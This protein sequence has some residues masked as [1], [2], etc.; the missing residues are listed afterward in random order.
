MNR[1]ILIVGAGQLGS[2]HL[3]ALALCL[4]PCEIFVVDPL[5]ESLKVAKSRFE[6]ING[7][8]K[9]NV[10]YQSYIDELESDHFEIA[11]ISTNA[12][13]RSK[14]IK[15]LL[16][17]KSISIFILEK[18][19]FQ[20][21]MEYD[22]IEMLF[23]RTKSKAF[24]NC[25]RRMF[26]FYK[27]VK[28]SI[29]YETPIHIEVIGNAWGLG[30]NSIHFIDLF[31]FL[32]GEN[33]IDW[34]SYLDDGYLESKRQGFK[35][36]TGSLT[37]RSPKGNSLSLTS[38]RNGVVNTSVRIS[39]PNRRYV[40][41]ESIGRAWIVEFDNKLNI[42]EIDFTMKFQSQLTNIVVKQ[43]F[44]SGTCELTTYDQSSELHLNFIKTI[45]GHYN[46]YQ[47]I[48]TDICPIT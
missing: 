28:E 43:L 14:V 20:S 3:Q 4:T 22:E 35:E 9:H 2:R 5:A 40:I 38:Y 17:T 16:T 13:K 41:E 34:N 27:E 15:Q 10:Y 29:F 30:C 44:E 37:G 33:I 48:K 47:D 32:T 31:N 42:S 39:T 36:F 19:L 6:E 23:K 46:K 8:S 25:P 1:N 12:D 11:I 7:H 26:S 24:V 21:V 18:V 45:L